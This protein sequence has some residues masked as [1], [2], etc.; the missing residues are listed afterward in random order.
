VDENICLYVDRNMLKTVF[1]NLIQNSIKFTEN[2]GQLTV[3]AADKDDFV[4]ISVK[5][6]GVGM[7]PDLLENIFK[8]G[9]I[10]SL[11][12]T[13]NEHGSG[14]G[15]LLCKEFVELE[16]GKIWVESSVGHGSEFKFTLPK[17]VNLVTDKQ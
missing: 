2:N 14:L 1:R 17:I 15:L 13:A 5:D 10:Q 12:G 6:T 3:L 4:E 11:S 9:G 8:L 7:T 16:G